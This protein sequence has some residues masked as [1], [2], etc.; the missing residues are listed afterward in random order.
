MQTATAPSLMTVL[1][2]PRRRPFRAAMRRP[3]F[4]RRT[5]AAD[6]VDA[7]EQAGEW[8]LTYK[9]IRQFLMAYTACFVVVMSM[10]V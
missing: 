6:A 4:G 5:Q 7:P 3:I 10:I 9:D 2:P 8:I 1:A